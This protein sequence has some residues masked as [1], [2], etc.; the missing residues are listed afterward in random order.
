LVELFDR[1][2]NVK[3]PE[4]ESRSASKA[5]KEA[6]GPCYRTGDRAERGSTGVLALIVFACASGTAEIVCV[7]G[8]DG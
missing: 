6:R 1:V 7:I 3:S 5:G 2:A 8:R 4:T